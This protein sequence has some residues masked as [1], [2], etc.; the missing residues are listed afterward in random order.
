MRSL[1]CRSLHAGF[2]PADLVGVAAIPADFSHINPRTGG[3]AGKA[4]PKLLILFHRG[5]AG[6]DQVG[7]RE[8]RDAGSEQTML[9]EVRAAYSGKVV[10]AHDLEVY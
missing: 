4:K 2:P 5:N 3:I 8:C 1:N 6:C 10:A 9:Q 7:T